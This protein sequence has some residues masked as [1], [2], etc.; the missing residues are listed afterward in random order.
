MEIP[1]LSSILNDARADGLLGKFIARVIL[2]PKE[3]LTSF[4][5]RTQTFRVNVELSTYHHDHTV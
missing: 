3:R 4:D 1:N 2:T 5:L